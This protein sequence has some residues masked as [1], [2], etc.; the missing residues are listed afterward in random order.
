M[1][2]LCLVMSC[3]ILQLTIVRQHCHHVATYVDD[4]RARI[5]EGYR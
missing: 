1:V 2:F 5:H 4:L 3:A